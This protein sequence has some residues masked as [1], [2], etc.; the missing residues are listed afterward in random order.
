MHIYIFFISLEK[1]KTLSKTFDLNKYDIEIIVLH[2]KFISISVIGLN[3]IEIF[4]ISTSLV[5]I[6]LADNYAVLPYYVI[7]CFRR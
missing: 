1:S 6:F 2:L 7:C 4:L 3:I 5:L